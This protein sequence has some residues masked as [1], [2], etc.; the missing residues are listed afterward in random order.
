M[1]FIVDS[2]SPE[3]IAQMLIGIALA[4][5]LEVLYV[6]AEIERLASLLSKGDEIFAVTTASQKL[7]PGLLALATDR[8][9]FLKRRR[10]IGHWVQLQLPYSAIRFVGL[11]EIGSERRL[12]LRT[13]LRRRSMSFRMFPSREKAEEISRLLTSLSAHARARNL[14]ATSESR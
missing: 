3:I 10:I 6:A 13:T 9:I 1:S 11:E 2:E 7:M 14:Y 4:D 12:R 8:M 5:D